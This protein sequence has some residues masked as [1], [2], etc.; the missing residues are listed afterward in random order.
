MQQSYGMTWK[1]AKYFRMI[2]RWARKILDA[3]STEQHNEI[4]FFNTD[5]EIRHDG[6]QNSSIKIN[7]FNDFWFWNAFPFKLCWP[8]GCCS[9]MKL[10][11]SITSLV[12]IHLVSLAASGNHFSYYQL[13]H[14]LIILAAIE[15][16]NICQIFDLCLN[17]GTCYAAQSPAKGTLPYYCQCPSCYSG[18]FWSLSD[19][20]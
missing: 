20:E 19:I 10:F 5:V 2:A 11:G 18:T 3:K 1:I 4:L 13:Y 9:E 17:G 6:I 14:H 8:R 16:A 15:D 7:I 12:L